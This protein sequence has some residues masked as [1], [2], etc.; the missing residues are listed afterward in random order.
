MGINGAKQVSKLGVC[1]NRTCVKS[2][3]R[4]GVSWRRHNQHLVSRWVCS[5]NLHIVP[6]ACFSDVKTWYQ[7]GLPSCFPKT[8]VQNEGYD[9]GT[10]RGWI[11]SISHHFAMLAFNG[12]EFELGNLWWTLFM[13]GCMSNHFFVGSSLK[14]MAPCTF[15]Q[16]TAFN[17][18]TVAKWIRISQQVWLQFPP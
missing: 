4:K 7:I 5:G 15:G 1:Q 16:S 10:Y 3:K 17:L 6:L 11:K 9:I 18:R 2:R 14:F 12:Y 8:N 13:W